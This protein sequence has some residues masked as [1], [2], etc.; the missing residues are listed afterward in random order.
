[1]IRRSLLAIGLVL[2]SSISPAALAIPTLQVGV[3]GGTGEGTYGNY[4]D[5]TNPNE[6]DTAV[7]SGTTLYVAGAF[8]PNDVRIGSRYPFAGAS[9]PDWS[10]FGFD[11]TFNG[12][13]AVLM[14]TVPGGL[15]G[16]SLTVNGASAF[17]TSTAYESGFKVPN[18]P[19]NHAPINETPDVDRSYLFFN[20]G[21]FS[22][23]PGTVPDF[24]DETGSAPGEIKTL[25]LAL[26]DFDWVH[27]DLFALVTDQT[28]PANDLRFTTSLGGN[29]GSHDVTWR[30]GGGP[31]A[32][33]PE[34]GTL[35][36]IGSALA[37]LGLRRRLRA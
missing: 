6:D 25:I 7:T 29:P 18:P 23:S 10:F 34:P 24:A 22:K 12:K 21:D 1:M 2:L 26:S 17:F 35:L 13:G 14:A 30:E 28:G 19:S 11:S 16:G 4:L 15:A 36:L 31:P 33:I 32:E 9:M 20:V 37:A 3:P 27:F 8:G 5:L